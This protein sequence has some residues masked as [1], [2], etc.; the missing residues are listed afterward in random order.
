MHV[1][2][3][4]FTR[5]SYLCLMSSHNTTL[6]V[7]PIFV[8][9]QTRPCAVKNQDETTFLYESPFEKFQCENLWTEYS[10]RRWPVTSDSCCRDRPQ[11][12]PKLVR[13]V[14][15]KFHFLYAG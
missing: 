14:H 6:S 12:G 13:A 10:H 3:W 9:F 8:I 7:L 4:S 11:G 5:V 2:Y 1:L 15:G